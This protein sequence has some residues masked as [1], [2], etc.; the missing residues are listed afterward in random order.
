LQANKLNWKLNHDE[1]L[2]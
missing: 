2:M 1:Q